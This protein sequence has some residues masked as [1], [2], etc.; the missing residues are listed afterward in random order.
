[1]RTAIIAGGTGLIGSHCVRE[2]PEKYDGVV[3]LV[4]RPSGI[5]T[6]HVIDFD[7]M[8]NVRLDADA[9]V[10]C[11]LGT[12]IRKAGSQE[13]FRRVDFEYVVGLAR[14][15]ADCHA[16]QFI[17]V[18]SVGADP[19]SSNFYLRVKGEM[20]RAVSALPL[21]AVHIFR[22]SLLLGDRQESRPAERVAIA[23]ARVAGFAFA[24]P[25]R[26]YHPVDARTVASAMIAAALGD[27]RGVRSYEHESIVRLAGGEA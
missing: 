15:A 23:A 5:S 10:F 12:T 4:R 3:S 25:L 7:R 9:D 18:S 20:E 6:E 1:M 8:E 21:K 27:A 19:A 26:K 22:P 13:A 24:G 2:L 16:R 17:V 14:R 11:A